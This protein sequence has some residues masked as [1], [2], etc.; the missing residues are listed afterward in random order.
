MT[1]PTTL[2]EVEA[3]QKKV[4]A[5]R[6][7]APQLHA[8]PTTGLAFTTPAKRPPA[9]PEYIPY[10][11][12]RK[13]MNKLE[14]AYAQH[15]EFRKQAGEIEWWAFEPMRVR[16]ADNT[17]YRPDFGVLRDGRLEFHETKGW[18]REAARVRLNVAAEHLPFSFYLV[19]Q[20]N[21]AWVITPIGR[22]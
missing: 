16:L 13:G 1:L 12:K 8:D 22:T 5:W 18:M 3:H 6:V 15:L 9:R 10:R 2:A 20:R 11:E 7:H 4:A 19:K 21:Q 17:F 14:A